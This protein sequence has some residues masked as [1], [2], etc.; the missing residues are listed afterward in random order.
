MSDIQLTAMQKM[1]INTLGIDFAE[2]N[3]MKTKAENFMLAAQSIA[4]KQTA[5]ENK[6]D[7]IIE[8]LQPPT[9]ANHD[10]DND[11]RKFR[12]VGQGDC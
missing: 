2:I 3:A 7:Y 4:E 12:I 9:G 6:L 1:L 8:H 11:S 10:R 5:L